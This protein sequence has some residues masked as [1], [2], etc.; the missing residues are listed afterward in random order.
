MSTEVR[1]DRNES[2]EGL[3][4]QTSI[5]G[6]R[7]TQDAHDEDSAE[8]GTQRNGTRRLLTESNPV[9]QKEPFATSNG[10]PTRIMDK[11]CEPQEQISHK[12]RELRWALHIE[13][14]GLQEE[15]LRK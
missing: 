12:M 5:T 11:M 4:G 2:S 1:S 3:G 10:T 15:I 9:E 14:E 13:R 8:R 6:S 7:D